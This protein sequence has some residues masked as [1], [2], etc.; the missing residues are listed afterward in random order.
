MITLSLR[1]VR[2]VDELWKTYEE[3]PKFGVAAFT[4]GHEGTSEVVGLLDEDIAHL[5][6][7]SSLSL[8][9]TAVFLGKTHRHLSSAARC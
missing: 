4:E 7:N 1:V 8:N 9:D 6:A 5:L 2:Y 3:V